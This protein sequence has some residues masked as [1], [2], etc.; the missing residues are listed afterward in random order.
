L[1]EEGFISFSGKKPSGSCK[2]MEKKE[3]IT[4][5]AMALVLPGEKIQEDVANGPQ[6]TEAVK[7]GT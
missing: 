3:R 4:H 5:K 6:E 2:R 1:P 7:G